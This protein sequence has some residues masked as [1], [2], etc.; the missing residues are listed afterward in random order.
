LTLV[1]SI[2]LVSKSLESSS[3]LDLKAIVDVALDLLRARKSS[4]RPQFCV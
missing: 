2:A 1:A 4:H 3:T